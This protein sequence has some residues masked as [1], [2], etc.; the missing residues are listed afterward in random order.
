MRSLQLFLAGALAACSWSGIPEQEVLLVRA[1]QRM[2]ENLARLPNYTCT[3]TIERFRSQTPNGRLEFFDRLRLEVALADRKELFAWPGAAKFEEADV[4]DFVRHGM[5]GTGNFALHAKALFVSREPTFTYVGEETLDG[6]RAVRFDFRA[7]QLTSDYRLESGGHQAVVGY[8]GSFWA[9]FETLDLLRLEVHA[10]DIPPELGISQAS[11]MLWYAPTRI[12]ASAFLLPV[13]SELTMADL[14]GRT[15]QN[16]TTFSGCRQYLGESTV[17]FAEPPPAAPVNARRLPETSLPQGLRLEVALQTMIDSDTSAV[18]DPLRATLVR[19]LSGPATPPVE[20]DAVVEGRIVRMERRASP[21]E[22]F[23]VGLRFSALESGPTRA[24]F[25]A[26]L[27]KIR[28]RS[29]SHAQVVRVSQGKGTYTLV[30]RYA[31]FT[32]TVEGPRPG[33]GLLL[34]DGAR[35]RLPT[36]T[37]MIWVTAPRTR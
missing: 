12:G 27:E 30:R 6:R 22:H 9:D 5:I 35:V 24:E 14:A 18:G 23:L 36:G 7:P 8:H 21:I 32:G 31:E 10:D 3:Q 25:T 16:R 13:R 20:K 2:A 33:V 26:A 29:G 34:I 19:P 11:D 4:R 17:S 28:V 1:K 15:D 37:L